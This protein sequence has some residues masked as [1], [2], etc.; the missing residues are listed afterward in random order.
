MFWKTAPGKPPVS[1][2]VDSGSIRRVAGRVTGLNWPP[3][4]QATRRDTTA[5]RVAS[6]IRSSSAEV[7]A[8][9]GVKRTEFAPPWMTPTPFGGASPLPHFPDP[10]LLI[11]G[12]KAQLTSRP[13]PCTPVTGPFECSGHGIEPGHELGA[14]RADVFSRSSPVRED[15]TATATSSARGLVVIV[16]P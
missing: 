13:V 8:K 3:R 1:G 5:A 7:T 6:T 16:L 4:P 11:P 15:S 2:A 14:A 12:S 10:W 9:C